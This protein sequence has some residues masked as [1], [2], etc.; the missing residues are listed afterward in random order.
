M[1]K[2]FARR[3]G[4][5]T[6]RGARKSKKRKPA[7]R[8]SP[9]ARVLFHG[10][11]FVIGALAGAAIVILTAYGPELLQI[12]EK[13]T[14]EAEDTASQSQPLEFTFPD[15]LKN[16][17]VMADPEPYAVPEQQKQNLSRIYHIQAASFRSKPDAD[18]LRARLLLENLPARTASSRVNG[19]TWYRVVV[20]PFEGQLDA[21]RAMTRLREQGLSAIRIRED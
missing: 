4:A 12:Q 18:Q 17:E 7:K 11:S 14:A 3:T 13:A 8:V 1:P 20:G 2:D 6:G 9:A 16:S 5:N 10:P 19:Q 15:A 21:D